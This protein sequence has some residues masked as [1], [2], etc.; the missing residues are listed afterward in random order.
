[1]R[2]KKKKVKIFFFLSFVNLEHLASISSNISCSI[3]ASLT[4]FKARD[5]PVERFAKRI[6]YNEKLPTKLMN[7]L[8]LEHLR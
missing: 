6:V 1:M 2:K 4:S 8:T 5:L 7:A 3:T